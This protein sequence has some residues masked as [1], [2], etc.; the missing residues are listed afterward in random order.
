MTYD[1]LTYLECPQILNQKVFA[2]VEKGYLTCQELSLNTS[3][4]HLGGSIIRHTT[5]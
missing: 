4:V 1:L 2:S 5:I 3:P